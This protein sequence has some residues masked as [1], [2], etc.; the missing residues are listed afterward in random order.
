MSCGISHIDRIVKAVCKQIITVKITANARHN[1]VRIQK[2]A[3]FGVIVAAPEVV[4]PC[5]GVVII[6]A[7]AE[8]VEGGGG[9]LCRRGATAVGNGAEPSAL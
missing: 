1:A 8:G 2:P 9:A 6:T 7:V 5:L 4:K 3:S